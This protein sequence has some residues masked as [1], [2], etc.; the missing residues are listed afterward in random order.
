MTAPAEFQRSGELCRPPIG[1]QDLRYFQRLLTSERF[2]EQ[3]EAAWIW[4][5]LTAREGSWES[6][7]RALYE[8][9]RIDGPFDPAERRGT[10]DRR[11]AAALAWP[12]GVRVRKEPVKPVNDPGAGRV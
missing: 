10:A 1:N 4:G 12:H 2:E 6:A 5:V 9:K 11:Q 8:R 3:L 7:V